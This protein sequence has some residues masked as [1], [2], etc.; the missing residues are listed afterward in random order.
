MH[1]SPALTVIVYT[2]LVATNSFRNRI[3]FGVVTIY[4]SWNKACIV[5]SSFQ[6]ATVS[7]RLH[8]EPRIV[9]YP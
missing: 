4:A 2:L 9:S 8:K 1:L 7:V 3:G 5:H 6:Y